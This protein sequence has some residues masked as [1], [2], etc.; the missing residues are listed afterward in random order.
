MKTRSRRT[1]AALVACLGLIG[2]AVAVTA[3]GHQTTKLSRKG[4]EAE[5][6]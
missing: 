2:F 4:C 1:V 6:S 3:P 5:D